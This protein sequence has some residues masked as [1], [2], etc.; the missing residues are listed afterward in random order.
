MREASPLHFKPCAYVIEL[1]AAYSYTTH[2]NDVALR[3]MVQTKLP[4]LAFISQAAKQSVEAGSDAAGAI[5]T[6][7]LFQ[8]KYGFIITFFALSHMPAHC[9]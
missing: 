9:S 4:A 8:Y 3:L 7:L 5:I 6:N 2:I 1:Y